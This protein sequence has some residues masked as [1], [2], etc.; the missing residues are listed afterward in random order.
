MAAE[1][2]TRSTI[3]L[4]ELFAELFAKLTARILSN[5]SVIMLMNLYVGLLYNLAQTSLFLSTILIGSIYS[6]LNIHSV[7][8]LDYLLVSNHIARSCIFCR[9]HYLASY[10]LVDR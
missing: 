8:A 5:L 7:F 1:L 9:S 10:L 6:F 4:A 3:I 2:F